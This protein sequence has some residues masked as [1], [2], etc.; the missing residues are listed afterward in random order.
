MFF[1]TP[2]TRDNQMADIEV[3]NTIAKWSTILY[4]AVSSH[5]A[6]AGG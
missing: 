5:G 4:A 2:V 1:N 6:A 3:A